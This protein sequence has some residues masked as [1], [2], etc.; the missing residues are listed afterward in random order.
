M[1]YTQI[2][3]SCDTKD[4]DTVSAVMSMI[5]NGLMIEDYSDINETFKDV[6]AD[7]IDDGLLNA[8]KSR[9]AVSV[10]ISEERNLQELLYFL[11]ERISADKI[12]C[13]VDVL[14]V[15]DE[16]WAESWKKYYHPIKVGERVVIVPA[17]EKYEK[18]E[19]ELPLIMDPGMAFGSGTHETT[20][21]VMTEIEKYI[22]PGCTVLDVGTG[23][24][25]LSIAASLLGA[26]SVNAYDI[27]PTAVRIAKENAEINRCGNIKVDVSDL[28]SNVER[29]QYDL[30]CANIVADIIIRMSAELYKYSHKDTVFIA[31][32]ILSE[33]RDE[34]LSAMKKTPFSYVSEKEENGW[35][36]LVF[37][38]NQIS[39]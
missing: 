9:A 4:L 39:E 38:C 21:L 34:V 24:G 26:S 3:V 35:C 11:K 33:R 30:I 32:G 22:K 20:R 7:L 31:S 18:K 10:F 13:E 23:S 37:K 14:N 17:W 2:K 15:S 27:D 19:N 25:I 29:K 16:E 5:D 6:Y 1:T 36:V 8:D 28:L 12:E